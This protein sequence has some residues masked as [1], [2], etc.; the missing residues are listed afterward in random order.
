MH[1]NSKVISLCKNNK[2]PYLTALLK[3][4]VGLLYT[5]I[6][7]SVSPCFWIDQTCAERTTY[8]G[9]EK[10]L[11]TVHK[12]Q[13]DVGHYAYILR[14]VRLRLEW[15]YTLFVWSVYFLR[16]IVI[17]TSSVFVVVS[18]RCVF[19]FS[20]SLSEV[21]KRT[22]ATTCC[23]PVLQTYL[24]HNSHNSHLETHAKRQHA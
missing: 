20:V 5:R 8:C 12:T 21:I 14:S 9:G 17:I 13:N 22:H 10:Y 1:W 24:F 4:F 6:N 15:L 7:P 16:Y 3:C 11:H 23:F 18:V 19:P 2:F